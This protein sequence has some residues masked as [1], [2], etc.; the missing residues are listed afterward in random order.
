MYHKFM[1]ISGC[2]KIIKQDISCS[3]TRQ[4]YTNL[5]SVHT[6]QFTHTTRQYLKPFDV[7]INP[8]SNSGVEYDKYLDVRVNN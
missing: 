8:C 1:D 4:L 5:I 3:H 7:G 6:M 2:C